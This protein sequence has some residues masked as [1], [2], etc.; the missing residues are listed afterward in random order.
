M[1]RTGARDRARRQLTETLSVLSDGAALLGKSR[2]LVEHIDTPEVAQYLAD[3]D[4]FCA[5]PFPAQVDQHPDNQAVDEFAAAMKTKLAKA[6]ANGRHGWSESWVQDKH[7]ADLL[8]GHVPKGN[9][10]NFEDIANFAMMLHQRG[11]DPME[12]TLAFNNAK[13]DLTNAGCRAQKGAYAATIKERPILF[14]GAMVRAILEGRKTVT[15]RAIQFPLIDRATGCDLAGSEIGAADVRN[16]CPYGVP[17]QR[18]WVREAWIPSPDAGHESWGNSACNYSDWVRAGKKIG[19]IPLDLRK[20]RNCIYRANCNDYGFR[21]R[22]SIHMPRWACRILLEI[23]AVRI[24]RLQDIS[25]EQA[26]AE[27]VMSCEQD[28][29]P[30]GNDYSPLELFSGLWT[31]I[32]GDGS[33]QS[34]PWVWVVEFK[35][36][37]P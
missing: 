8:V 27:G 33:W 2:T 1:S 34:N 24:E 21:W 11:A 16:N 12:L 25:A 4:S 10:G 20:P 26:L 29:D 28:I 35:Q 30:D 22:P 17:G 5:R 14:N 37:K 13:L 3:L 19:G 32:N 23:T 6:R 36:V 15:R 9:A 31:M 7:L 18:L